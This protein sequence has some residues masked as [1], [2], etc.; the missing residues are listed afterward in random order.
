MEKKKHNCIKCGES[1]QD[2]EED[3]Y[4]CSVCLK[5]KNRIAEEV[6]KKMANRPRKT[7]QSGLAQYDAI[8]KARGGQ[9]PNIN[10]LGIKL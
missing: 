8:L 10:D 2:D 1:Y 3:A 4:Y 5:E 6:D 7:Q 9:Y